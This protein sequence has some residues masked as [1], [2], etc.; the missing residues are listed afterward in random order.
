MYESKDVRELKDQSA[1]FALVA[2]QLTTTCE[3]RASP[4]LFSLLG[5]VSVLQNKARLRR[6]SFSH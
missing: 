5:S 2:H 6:T 3:Y 4:S 1:D